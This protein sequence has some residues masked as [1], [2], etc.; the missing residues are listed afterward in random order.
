MVPSP[1]V[2]E[3]PGDSLAGEYAARMVGWQ[4]GKL[5]CFLARL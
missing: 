5:T 4:D 2:E 1:I 3:E